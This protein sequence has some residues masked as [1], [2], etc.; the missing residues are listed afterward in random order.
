V[1]CT[2]DLTVSGSDITV[3]GS[4]ITVSGSDITVSGGQAPRLVSRSLRGKQVHSI[5]GISVS[6]G[7]NTY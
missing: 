4:D 3:S 1:Q 6:D 5:G 2:V 7:T